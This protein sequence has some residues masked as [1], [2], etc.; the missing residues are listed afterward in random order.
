MQYFSELDLIWAR[1]LELPWVWLSSVHF[2]VYNS[3][4][5]R[6]G[7]GREKGEWGRMCRFKKEWLK[8][9]ERNTCDFRESIDTLQ[10]RNVYF[11]PTDDIWLDINNYK[12]T[13]QKQTVSRFFFVCLPT[14]SIEMY[15]H[16]F[17]ILASI[18]TPTTFRLTSSSNF[19]ILFSFR[20]HFTL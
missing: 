1:L 14:T 18:F 20:A 6:G 2:F 11:N 10:S 8:L 3:W 7:G 16:S 13:Q 5:K 15:L 4:T 19:P 17:E 9:T 12:K